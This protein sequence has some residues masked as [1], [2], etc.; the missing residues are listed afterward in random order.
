MEI[1]EIQGEHGII[2]RIPTGA[3]GYHAWVQLPG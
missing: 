3:F 2:S 1:K